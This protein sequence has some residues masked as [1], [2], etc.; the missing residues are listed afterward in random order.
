MRFTICKSAAHVDR[1]CEALIHA[2]QAGGSGDNVTA[3]GG[4]LKPY[5]EHSDCSCWST[6]NAS[7]T[8]LLVP[9]T[10]LVPEAVFLGASRVGSCSDIALDITSS[11]GSGCPSQPDSSDSGY[12]C[13]NPNYGY[14][15]ALTGFNDTRSALPL[16]LTVDPSDKEPDRSGCDGRGTTCEDPIPLTGTLHIN[17]LAAGQKYAIYRW[18]S[19]ESAFDYTRPASVHRF[20]ASGPSLNYTDTTTIISNGTTYYRCVDDL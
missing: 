14:G 6:V 3:L 15:W 11:T 20:T 1:A 12:I 2:A 8:K 17:G 4:L 16:S 9:D 10:P 13:L 7:A 18:D 5:C 19:V